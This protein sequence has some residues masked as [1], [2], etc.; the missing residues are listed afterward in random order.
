[1]PHQDNRKTDI[2]FGEDGPLQNV[3]GIG[4]PLWAVGSIVAAVVAA[5]IW[6]TTQLNEINKKLDNAAGDRWR[7]TFQRQYNWDLE[8]LNKGAINVPDP[9]EIANKLR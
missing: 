1:M 9:D 5:T 8:R 4:V 7:L 2:S 6:I 3:K